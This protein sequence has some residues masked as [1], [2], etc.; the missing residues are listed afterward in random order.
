MMLIQIL[1]TTNVQ[2][3]MNQLIM[4]LVSNATQ[5]YHIEYIIR[6]IKNIIHHSTQIAVITYHYHVQRVEQ[7]DSYIANHRIVH[8]VG[9]DGPHDA[10]NRSIENVQPDA[11]NRSIIE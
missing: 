1:N 10:R 4:T 6:V 3:V 2:F 8:R 7:K 9:E 11:R 5:T